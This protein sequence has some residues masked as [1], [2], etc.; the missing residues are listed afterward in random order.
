MKRLAIFFYYDNDGIV[1]D[2]VFFLLDDIIKNVDKILIV[3]NGKLKPKYQAKLKNKYKNIIYRE[4]TGFDVWAY[5]EGIEYIGWQYIKNYD[6]LILFNH[7]IFGPL[8]PF[9]K[10]FNEMSKRDLDFWGITKSLGNV[11]LH[12]PVEAIIA[13]HIQSYFIVVRNKLLKDKSFK[14]YW[15]SRPP[16]NNFNDALTKHEFIFTEYFSKK[17][18]KYDTYINM[19]YFQNNLSNPTLGYPLYIIKNNHCPIVKRK[20]F[21]LEDGH[22]LDTQTRYLPDTLDYIKNNTNYDV[23]LIYKNLTRTQPLD[24]L[25]KKL[26]LNYFVS[27]KTKQYQVKKNTKTAIIIDIFRN[28]NFKYLFEYLDNIPRTTDIIFFC[29]EENKKILQTITTSIKSKITYIK[30]LKKTYNQEIIFNIPFRHIQKYDFV[31]YVHNQIIITNQCDNFSI[32]N[33]SHFDNFL[34]SQ[35]ITNNI[36]GLLENHPEIGLL[37]S[38][39]YKSKKYFYNIDE[40]I[41]Q[42]LFAS[43]KISVPNKNLIFSN[44]NFIW[45]RTKTYSDIW[46]IFP[47]KEKNNS[48]EI[49][50][51]LPYYGQNK[52]FLTGYIYN[53]EYLKNELVCNEIISDYKITALTNSQKTRDKI[54]KKIFFSFFKSKET[55]KEKKF[56]LF[57]LLPI[58]S[59][60]NKGKIK[61][62]YFLNLIPVYNKKI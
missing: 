11:V 41:Y 30:K 36:I 62:L 22:F 5:K 26:N 17:G 57:N 55:A 10:M 14:S 2:Y 12:Q 24:D 28:D 52:G 20:A 32:I 51:I 37:L 45:L 19:D 49:F 53:E 27:N 35:N 33:K 60:K 18:F 7:T 61:I 6:E 47:V 21:F 13:E 50:H 44:S 29:S 59:L 34:Q 43:F 58:F 1:D 23:S 46:K 54:I 31:G 40:N 16:I 9:S 39:I 48:K 25:I 3:V 56:Y 15:D 4:N 38:G 8:L 42:N